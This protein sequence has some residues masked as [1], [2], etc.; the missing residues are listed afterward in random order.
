MYDLLVWSVAMMAIVMITWSPADNRDGAVRGY[1]VLKSVMYLASLYWLGLAFKL[2]LTGST[3][4]RW[5]FSDL[6]WPLVI[7][8]AVVASL[9]W[10]LKPATT[11]KQR[12]K[13][14][15]YKLAHWRVGLGLGFVTATAYEFSSPALSQTGVG[16]YLLQSGT[17]DP[18]DVMYYGIGTAI[19]LFLVNLGSHVGRT[20]LRA[21]ASDERWSRLRAYRVPP[22]TVSLPCEVYDRE[23]RLVHSYT[24][25]TV[26]SYAL[27]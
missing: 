6:L 15:G 26:V 17:F 9:S 5:H 24:H 2:G 8:S 18:I 19:G 11:A 16:K 22:V 4:L 10:F 7:A 12:R 23:G 27:N 1:R 3:W 14:F 13:R 25:N 21:Q 20:E